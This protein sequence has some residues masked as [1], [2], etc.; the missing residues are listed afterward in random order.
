MT[1]LIQI[2]DRFYVFRDDSGYGGVW[3]WNI[4]DDIVAGHIQTHKW[5][6]LPKGIVTEFDVDDPP[7]TVSYVPVLAPF[8]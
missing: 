1:G 6:R 5:P 8:L 3:A 7:V 2:E 4:H